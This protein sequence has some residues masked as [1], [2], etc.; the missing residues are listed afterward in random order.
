MG[1]FHKRFVYNDL[2]ALALAGIISLLFA[3]TAY[4]AFNTSYKKQEYRTARASYI[5]ESWAGVSGSGI[6]LW[7]AKE[8]L[9]LSHENAAFSFKEFY[10][11]L[12]R[13]NFVI[14]AKIK[15][16]EMWCVKAHYNNVLPPIRRPYIPIAYCKLVI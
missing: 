12:L 2:M 16:K 7:E 4:G 5:E 1:L 6:R 11:P 8:L 9:K 3:Q 15:V 14:K 10:A 13:F